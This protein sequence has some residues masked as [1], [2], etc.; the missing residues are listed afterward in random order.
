VAVPPAAA[1]P[2]NALQ[3]TGSVVDLTGT[4]IVG[5]EV[6]VAG[7]IA[8]TDQRG[9]FTVAVSQ[10]DVLVTVRA[11]GFSDH[12][13]RVRVDRPVR[14]TL[15]PAGVA[16]SV[17]VTAGRFADRLA[18]TASAVTVVT[19]AAM[20]T[21]AQTTIDDALRSVPGFSLFRR[22][23]SRVANPTT[24]GVSLR[25]LAASGASRAL[26]LAEGIP[27]NDPYGGW[28]YW[29]R[30]PQTAIDRIEVVR[31]SGTE[32]LY[33]LNA[34]GGALR[35]ITRHPQ[36]MA[37]RLSIEGG[38]HGMV[39][40]SGYGG[41]R[42]GAWDGFVSAERY[43]LDGFPI[44][45]R[46]ER[47]P[48]DINAG[49]RYANALLGG[50]WSGPTWALGIRANWLDEDRENGTPLQANDTNLWSLA[51]TGRGGGFGGLFTFAAYGGET[52][53]D[54]SFSAVSSNRTTERLTFRQR[55]ASD[56]AAG[57][58]QWFR[59]WAGRTLLLGG[60]ALRVSGGG[61]PVDS[62]LQRDAAGYAQLGL[63]ANSRLRF[64]GGVRVGAWTT[65]RKLATGFSQRAWYVVPRIS[66]TW[67]RTPSM[68]FTASWSRPA[69]TPTLN[70]LYRD[71]QVGNVL[72]ASNA[73]LAPEDAQAA[74]AGILAQRGAASARIQGFWTRVDGA[75]T[76]VTLG[77][78]SGQ[79]MRQRRN[80]GTIRARGVEAEAEWRPITWASFLASTIFTDSRFIRSAEQGLEGK[81]VSQVPPWQGS[82]S[83][84]VSRGSIVVG[85]DWRSTGAQ[86][87]DDQN[88]FEL[89]AATVLDVYLGA[90]LRRGFRPFFAAENLFGAEVDVGRTP[91]RTIGTPRSV[92]LGLRL[93]LR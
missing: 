9:R 1:Q 64:V 18:D 47:G 49:L 36:A 34:I 88:R 75:V 33:G 14:M 79:I 50:G 46:D 52:D 62:G 2:T 81:R 82:L 91:V 40:G 56:N 51:V 43:G 90:N 44:V 13:R 3:L 87:D 24:Q 11:P 61:S 77:T 12:V 16:E 65:E 48:V 74:E 21:G 57:S 20:L 25:G 39:R 4:P 80:A 37:G 73:R 30:V 15:H 8:V 45:A 59:E 22:S 92:R 31:G 83:A 7:V 41:A 66:L 58:V 32:S 76:N 86:F 54:Q 69:R 85:A 67:A 10:A 17:T 26:V 6:S 89:R 60:E 71:F 78:S 35:L 93:F 27:L 19:S 23:S 68:S 55:I 38:Q 63:A 53:Y 29:D 5:A 72:T 42:R 84:R 28:V 70:E